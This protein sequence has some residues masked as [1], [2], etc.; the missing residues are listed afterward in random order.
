MAGR[1]KENGMGMYTADI[2]FVGMLK[3]RLAFT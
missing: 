2:V 1:R 3:H